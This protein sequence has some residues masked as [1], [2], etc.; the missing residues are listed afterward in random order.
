MGN[1]NLMVL[2]FYLVII[3]PLSHLNISV[4]FW[5]TFLILQRDHDGT[6][7]NISWWWWNNV[8]QQI[9]TNETLNIM[10]TKIRFSY[11][12]I[13]LPPC[14]SVIFL[15]NMQLLWK[16]GVLWHLS[17]STP[18]KC[19]SCSWCGTHDQTLGKHETIIVTQHSPTEDQ[20]WQVI[21]PYRD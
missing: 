20:Q 14:H 11:L 21:V 4:F 18:W 16:R 6:W 10:K 8:E 12:V 15:V 17:S 3:L 1:R 13:I 7:L 19:R 5:W 2:F 9:F